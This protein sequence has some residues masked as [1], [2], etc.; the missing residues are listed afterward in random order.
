MEKIYISP[1]M[2][3]VHKT[4]RKIERNTGK[5]VCVSPTG[6][7]PKQIS[8][9]YQA[10]WSLLA[11]YNFNHA[12]WVFPKIVVPQNGWWNLMVPNPMN[13]N[14]WFGGVVFPYSWVDTHMP[15]RSFHHFFTM[16]LSIVDLIHLHLRLR[17][18][19]PGCT[20]LGRMEL[21]EWW[22]FL[23]QP[24]RMYEMIVSNCCIWGVLRNF[25]FCVCCFFG[26]TSH[27]DK[28]EEPDLSFFA[29][30]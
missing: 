22:S 7:P 6:K 16:P 1:L 10:I 15:K 29:I 3:D 9:H 17:G 23:V 12:T 30:I 21:G 14:G 19:E 28:I 20:R 5:Q 26:R 8:E 4:H 18:E 27:M 11:I 25:W 13:T 2:S 24:K